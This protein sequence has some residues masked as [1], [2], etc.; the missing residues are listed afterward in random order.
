VKCAEH[1]KDG[2]AE[3]CPAMREA[4]TVGQLKAALSAIPDDTPLMVRAVDASD[5]EF[6]DE[7]VVVGAGFGTVD[8]GDGYGPEPDTLFGLECEVSEALLRTKPARPRRRPGSG[9]GLLAGCEDYATAIRK[10]EEI[11]QARHRAVHGDVADRDGQFWD[12]SAVQVLGCYLHAAGLAGLRAASVQ[13][14]LE[15]GCAS[16]TAA[17]I[18]A[19]HPGACREAS[20]TLR[21]LLDPRSPKT[22][23]MARFVG[24]AALVCAVGERTSPLEVAQ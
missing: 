17:E 2:C 9:A 4:W 6:A 11:I 12:S 5:P 3:C 15:K 22:Q 14:W 16:A 10:A 8:W 20:S 24:A 21:R 7:Q 1:G 19:A 18:L 13:A 23:A